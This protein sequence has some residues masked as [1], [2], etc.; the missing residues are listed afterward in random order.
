MDDNTFISEVGSFHP[1]WK[2]CFWDDFRAKYTKTNENGVNMQMCNSY[3]LVSSDD[4]T[5]VHRSL[6]V[7]YNFNVIN[8]YTN[9]QLRAVSVVS[10]RSHTRV[11]N[12]Q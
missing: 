9:R 2:S 12:H 4:T 11:Y 7:S 10:A 5:F 3:I 1:L 6:N 8:N